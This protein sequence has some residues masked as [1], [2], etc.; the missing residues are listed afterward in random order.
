MIFFSYYFLL[1]TIERESF[2]LFVKKIVIFMSLNKK[3]LY[4]EDNKIS[5]N[6]DKILIFFLV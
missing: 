1:P 3:K 6:K 4:F 5:K 2:I